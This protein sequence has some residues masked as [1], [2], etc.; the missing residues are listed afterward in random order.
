MFSVFLLHIGRHISMHVMN[1]TKYV[2]K[3]FSNSSEIIKR[4]GLT[5]IEN[6]IHEKNMLIHIEKSRLLCE[7]IGHH[8]VRMKSYD[9]FFH[10]ITTYW[11]GNSFV[12]MNAS[13]A[14]KVR[15]ISFDSIEKQIRKIGKF[16]TCAN[17]IYCD[18]LLRNWVVN[19]HTL[20]LIDMDIAYIINNYTM[21][22]TIDCRAFDVDL[23]IKMW[24]RCYY[25][26][27]SR[28]KYDKCPFNSNF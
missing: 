26:G 1:D 4:T 25:H 14:I 3:H 17:I 13:E 24:R 21:K 23:Q 2:V 27:K 16:L 7:P 22:K 11:A 18:A 5:D 15:N 28:D 6:F 12:D 10:T 20:T 8:V 9:D 19:N